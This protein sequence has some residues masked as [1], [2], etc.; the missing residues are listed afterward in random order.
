MDGLYGVEGGDEG[1]AEE[2]YPVYEEEGGAGEGRTGE[3]KPEEKAEDPGPV[4]EGGGGG[5]Y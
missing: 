4:D 3:P 2:P 1:G 5:L